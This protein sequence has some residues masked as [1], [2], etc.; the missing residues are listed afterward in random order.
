MKLFISILLLPL[1]FCSCQK[2]EAQSNE[3]KPTV[4][5]TNYPLY[6]FADRLAGDLC[7]VRFDAPAD[8]DPAFW[9]PD[10]EAIA[11]FQQAD[12]IL[13]NG[14]TYE[15]WISKTTLPE[16]T[17]ID[18]S[19][20]FKTNLI[21]T[22]DATSHAHGDGDL[23]NHAGTAFTTWLDL[24]QASQQAETISQSLVQL[25][26]QHKD[27]IIERNDELQQELNQLH[28][29]FTRVA[30]SIK[31]P[32]LASHPV[33]HYFARTYQ[34]KMPSLIWEP[35]MVLNDD[36]LE[37][38]QIQKDIYSSA[39]FFI[40]EGE[41]LPQLV[42]T[43]KQQGLTSIVISPCFNRPEEGDFLTVMKSNLQA[44]QSTI[45]P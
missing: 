19:K 15:K 6:Y 5:V 24:Q 1:L 25:L 26:P 22:N 40:W 9:Q 7:E 29:E 42:E 21:E 38:L 39:R 28:T 31:E 4:A 16:D 36:H 34:L 10:A 17:L 30:A 11:N 33:Y 14:A 37:E 45:Q 44:L 8:V 43:L 35:E 41:A 27:L 18:T 2:N 13:L 20:N 12:L 23:H 32:L 3:T